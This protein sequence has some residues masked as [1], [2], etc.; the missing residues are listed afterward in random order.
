MY[1]RQN[2]EKGESFQFS[3]YPEATLK[4][5]N[6]NNKFIESQSQNP[7]ACDDDTLSDS[8]LVKNAS[9]SQMKNL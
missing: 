6:F 7:N 1:D 2:R 9:D 3:M 8:E 4:F 5:K